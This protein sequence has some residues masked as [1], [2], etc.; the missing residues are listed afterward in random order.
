MLEGRRIVVGVDDYDMY[1]ELSR[2]RRSAAVYCDHRQVVAGAV[3][4]V[5][6][7][8]QSQLEVFYTTTHLGHLQSPTWQHFTQ[9]NV[10][11]N[12]SFADG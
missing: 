4:T 5:E 11:T 1:S 9:L 10:Y 7:P 3:L 12:V 8:R 6:T 2:P